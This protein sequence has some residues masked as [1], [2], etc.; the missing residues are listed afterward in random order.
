LYEQSMIEKKVTVDEL[1]LQPRGQNWK[2]G[3]G[4]T[5]VSR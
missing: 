5:E 1:F 3:W 4:P 2:V